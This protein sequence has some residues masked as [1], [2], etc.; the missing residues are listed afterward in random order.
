MLNNLLSNFHSVSAVK[1]VGDSRVYVE[2]ISSLYRVHAPP[3]SPP[4][5]S[6]NTTHACPLSS[7]PSTTICHRYIDSNNTLVPPLGFQINK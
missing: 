5:T 3:V 1:I 4:A 7:P 2:S 6:P